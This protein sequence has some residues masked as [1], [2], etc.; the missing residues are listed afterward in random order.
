LGGDF[1]NRINQ[2]LAARA[3]RLLLV[4]AVVAFAAPAWAF[5]FDWDQGHE[6]TQSND[7]PPPGTCDSPTCDGDCNGNSTRSPVYA[8]LGHAIWRNTD[9]TLRGRPYI[10]VYR[11]YNSNDP[12]VGLFGNGWSVCFDVALYPATSSGVQQRVY[13]AANGKRFIYEKQDDGRFKPP[14]GRFETVVEGIDNVTMTMLDGRRQ[15]FGLDG[16]L[17]ER[18]DTNGNRTSYSYDSAARPTRMADD[19]GRFL[20]IGYN[21]GGRVGSVTDHT[22]RV[23]R[24][25]YDDSGNLTDVTDPTGGVMRYTWQA[26]QPP[27][28]ANTYY[29]LLSVT[30]AAGVVLIRYT[31]NGNQVASYTEG[32]NTITYTRPTSNTALAGT[33]TRKDS[34]SATTSFTYGELGLVTEDVDGIGGRTGYT[35]DKN[36][37]ITATVDALSRTWP[38]DY[39]TLGRL[40]RSSN[41]LN[42]TTT[43]RYEGRDPRPIRITSPSGRV[44]RMSYDKQGN[45]LSTTD[46]SGAITRMTYN[47]RG[48]LKSITNALNQTTS[49]NYNAIGLPERITDPLGRQSTTAYDTLGRVDNVTNPAGETTRY[50]YD[51]LDRVTAITDA[52]DQ[53][54]RFGYDAAGRLSRVTDAKSSITRYEYDIHGRRSAEVAPDGRRTLY[55]YLADNLLNQ[56]IWPDGSIIVYGYDNNKRVRSET[57]GSETNIYSYNA[58]NQLTS[59]SGPGGT[60]SY[61]YD[62]AA[63]VASETSAGRTHTVKR[64][65]EGERTRLD[66]LDQ[67]QTYRRDVRGL[68]TGIASPAGDFSFDFNALG[69]R[70]QLS[71]P[72]GSTARYDFDAA[73][74]LT[75]L[76]HA[77]VFNAPYQ[78]SYDAAGRITKITGDGQPWSY[79]YDAAG[80]LIRVKQGDSTTT[81]TLDEVGNITDGRSYDVNHRLTADAT[82]DYSYDE[83]GNLILEQNRNTGARTEYSWNIKNQLVGFNSYPDANAISPTRTLEY[84]Y[85]PLGRRTSKRDNGQEQRFSYDGDDLVGTLDGSSII[86]TNVFSG[87]IDEPLASKTNDANRLLYADHLGSITAVV[88]DSTLRQEY[89]YGPYGQ[90]LSGSSKDSVPFRYTGREK[91]TGSLYYYRAR[92][93]STAMQRFVSPDPIGLDGGVNLYAYVEGDPVNNVDPTGEFGIPGA[94]GAAA[95]NFGTQFLTNL[96]MT[97]GDWR[98][99]LKCVDFGDVAISAAFGFVGPSFLSNVLGGKV[100]PAGLT[101]AQNRQIY[102]TM[103]LPA[104]FFF[105]K[106]S[107]PLRFGDDC[108]CQGLSLGNLLGAFAH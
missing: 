97:G 47:D 46:P 1:V 49:I 43:V 39:D 82:K 74:Q 27:A 73:G 48:D 98:R 81:Y 44:V 60:V 92:Y 79:S 94:A 87:A 32:A 101:A 35:Y 40:T 54:T 36:G 62:D 41:P 88:Q 6:P 10:G 70:T 51:A 72:N 85:D 3:L 107:P 65:A 96:Y 93:Y 13:K 77:G 99:A 84:V 50:R 2:T 91:D 102:F 86:A 25:R 104:G 59:A 21:G 12:V 24:Y 9:V 89:K 5:H 7:P 103:S 30:D 8:A 61:T 83:R 67:S 108:E 68:V 14:D 75:E 57:A 90:T 38:A 55:S 58:V 17:L 63:R 37:R 80:R 69:R 11:V 76:R 26:Y 28:D 42:E 78:H 45:L 20:R 106:G 100:G 31:Y 18:I 4:A 64:N 34:A 52:L 56:I 22:G 71:Y 95:F 15:V 66:Y 29:Q 33:V 19:N 16:R 23:W 53:T 105:K